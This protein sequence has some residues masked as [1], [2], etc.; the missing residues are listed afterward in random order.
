MLPLKEKKITELTEKLSS[1]PNKS[2][3]EENLKLKSE[4]EEI[5]Q[6]YSANLT[7]YQS[8]KEEIQLSVNSREQILDELKRLQSEK[9][10]LHNECQELNSKL[11]NIEQ[12]NEKLKDNLCDLNSEIISVSGQ[13]NLNQKI[14]LH[15]KMKEENNKL[16]EQ[17]Y[18][19]REDLRKKTGKIENLEKTMN[20][21]LFSN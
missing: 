19:L 7:E 17:N 4:I 16:K 2:Q 6:K 14:K 5:N 13:N 1:R 20:G 15:A 12:D 21:N 9:I 3:I 18:Q 11:H 10:S 8:M